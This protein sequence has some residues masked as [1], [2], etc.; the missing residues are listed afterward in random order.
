M[1]SANSDTHSA[2]WIA[3]NDARTVLLAGSLTPAEL[4]AAMRAQRGYATLDKNLGVRFS[5]NGGVL[6]STL[7]GASEA[8]AAE[9]RIWDPD[10]LAGSASDAVTRVEIVSDRGAVVRSLALSPAAG[11]KTVT[12]KVTGL[13]TKAHYFWVRVSTASADAT[14]LP[15]VTAWTAPV[16]TGR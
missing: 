14:G 4:Y 15:G 8:Y 12:W 10:A 5:V 13:P 2:D 1:P 11:V 6:G 9:V 3:G 16:W 7:P